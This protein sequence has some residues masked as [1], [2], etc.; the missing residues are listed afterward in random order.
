M[1]RRIVHNI[2]VHRKDVYYKAVLERDVY[3][4]WN[5]W[6]NGDSKLYDSFE[7]ASI[8]LN[9]LGFSIG[10]KYSKNRKFKCYDESGRSTE[11]V[12]FENYD[13]WELE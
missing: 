2:L 8:H 5:V 3:G 9:L 1:N 7:E 11:Y 12:T 13:I 10:K 6:I 4:V